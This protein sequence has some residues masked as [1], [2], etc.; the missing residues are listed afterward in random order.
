MAKL[1]SL[2]SSSTF[3]L[4][5]ND[6]VREQDNARFSRLQL[7]PLNHVSCSSVETVHPGYDDYAADK[8]GFEPVKP[9]FTFQRR[10]MECRI[11]ETFGPRNKDG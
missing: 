1:D 9:L 7:I 11:V 2:T 10:S 4:T 5:L 8:D 6:S 3:N